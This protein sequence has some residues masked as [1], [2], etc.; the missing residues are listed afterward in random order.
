[1]FQDYCRTQISKGHFNFVYRLDRVIERSV[2]FGFCVFRGVIIERTKVKAVPSDGTTEH[3]PQLPASSSSRSL[4]VQ[5]RARFIFF[6][7]AQ[8]SVGGETHTSGRGALTR[9]SLTRRLALAGLLRQL[10]MYYGS[11]FNSLVSL[12][13]NSFRRRFSAPHL[14]RLFPRKNLSESTHIQVRF[15]D[16]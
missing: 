5:L 2:L 10:C 14:L 16:C 7:N 9:S 4:A 13:C 8:R 15:I 12:T 1:M 6:A 3:P 11:V